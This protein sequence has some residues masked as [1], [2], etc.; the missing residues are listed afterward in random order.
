MNN[1]PKGIITTKNHPELKN[2]QVVLVIEV[3]PDLYIVKVSE[4]SKPVIVYK[5]DLRKL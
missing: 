3:T 4:R 5:Q 1:Y 2:G